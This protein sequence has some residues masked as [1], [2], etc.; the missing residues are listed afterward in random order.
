[1]ICTLQKIVSLDSKI[2]VGHDDDYMYVHVH[3]Y[4]C[5]LVI[6]RRG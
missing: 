2:V 3:A 1:M 5:I 6:Y 4:A